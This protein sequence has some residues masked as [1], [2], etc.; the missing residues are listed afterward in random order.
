MVGNI[1]LDNEKTRIWFSDNSEVSLIL[2]P[3]SITFI[4]D[5]S[6]KYGLESSEITDFP[7]ENTTSNISACS[8][9]FEKPNA[10]NSTS[11]ILTRSG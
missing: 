8:E 2:F 5:L 3:S 6:D 11:V 7:T 4:N 10:L 1:I 9:Q